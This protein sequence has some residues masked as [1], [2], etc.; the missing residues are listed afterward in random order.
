MKRLILVG[1]VL[2]LSLPLISANVLAKKD[3]NKNSQKSS[4][5]KALEASLAAETL[6]R[7]TGDT[8]LHDLIEAIQLTPGPKG[9]PGPAGECSCPTSV[10]E[11]DKLYK[12]LE[13]IDAFL[14][15]HTSEWSS[16]FIDN[17]NGTIRDMET[18]LV[19]LKDANCGS[20]L[21]PDGEANWY[22]A[23]EAVAALADG[24]C[25]LT[26]GSAPGDWRLP[27][28]VEYLN[29]L[30]DDYVSPALVNTV[31]DDVWEEGDAFYG[32]QSSTYW[33]GRTWA[34]GSDT[35]GLNAW[36]VSM[37]DKTFGF[38]DKD[39]NHYSVWPVRAR[40]DPAL[41]D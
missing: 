36:V 12:K 1:V 20:L 2:M 13:A 8:N 7:E 4:G 18:G 30:S 27:H 40:H 3:G 10:E 29:F 19:W 31:G 33:S 37:E 11:L 21:D 17:H 14:Y 25:G 23:V 16:R 5:K 34:G 24:T 35:T 41:P 26:D 15:G 32:V 28:P 9:D 38:A 22:E 39:V 6:A